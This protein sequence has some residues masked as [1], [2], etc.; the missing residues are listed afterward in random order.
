MRILA[1]E[2]KISAKLLNESEMYSVLAGHT[3]ITRSIRVVTRDM[4]LASDLD[5]MIQRND[6]FKCL[7]DDGKTI[8]KVKTHNKTGRSINNSPMEY[9]YHIELYEEVNTMFDTISIDGEEVYLFKS[10]IDETSETYEFLISGSEDEILSFRSK[11]E[12]LANK[13]EYFEVVLSENST[14]KKSDMMKMRFGAMCFW[15]ENGGLIKQIFN[16]V[17]ETYDQKQKPFRFNNMEFVSIS[18]LELKIV[19]L[20]NDL[21]K[22]TELLKENGIAPKEFSINNETEM[23][24]KY[25]SSEVEDAELEFSEL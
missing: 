17:P 11:R 16:L 18:N 3:I 4:S 24:R 10:K 6:R 19:A 13:G 21:D 12:S 20:Q 25:F 5:G 15:S 8:W 23:R 9:E 22:I 7:D 2:Y 1:N 14:G